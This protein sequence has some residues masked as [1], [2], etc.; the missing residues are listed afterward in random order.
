MKR[1]LRDWIQEAA[2][3]RGRVVDPEL[4]NFIFYV[5]SLWSEHRFQVDEQIKAGT[6][7][8]DED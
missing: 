4:E 1:R 2:A 7:A 8:P 6:Y 5:A 3:E